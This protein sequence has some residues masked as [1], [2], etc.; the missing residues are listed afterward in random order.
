M[1]EGGFRKLIASYKGDFIIAAYNKRNIVQDLHAIYCF[2]N[3]FYRKDFIADFTVGTKIDIRVFP[4]GRPDFFQFNFFQGAFPAGSLFGFGGISREAGN[5]LLQFLDFFFFFLIG[6]LH[7]LDKELAGFIPEIIVAGIE[8]NLAIVN[9]C[10]MGTY[11]IQ[12]IAVVGYDDDRVVEINKEIFQ[13]CDGIQVQVVG[14]LIQKKDIRVA[15]KGFGK[16]DF[17]FFVTV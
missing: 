13:P 11:F 2:G 9:I 8:L 4:A 17:D 3:P 7:L 10:G 5:E 6:F 1:E 14:R 15:K 12:E 16:E